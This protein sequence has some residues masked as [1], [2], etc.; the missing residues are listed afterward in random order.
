MRSDERVQADDLSIA[1]TKPPMRLGVPLSA[2]YGNMVLC[3]MGWMLY[4]AFT[5]DQGMM[6]C[7]VCFFI[8][9]LFQ[10]CMYLIS[11]RDRFGLNIYW[12]L[13]VNFRETR[14]KNFWGN[15]DSYS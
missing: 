5:G 7:L 3:F 2:F 9:I 14:N 13:V 15:T 8:W 11:K 10:M 12:Q 6:S 1:L 4:R